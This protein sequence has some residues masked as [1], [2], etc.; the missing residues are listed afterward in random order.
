[1]LK[2]KGVEE[3][4]FNEIKLLNELNFNNKDN[5]KSDKY[6]LSLASRMQYYPTE[7]ILV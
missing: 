7:D 5:E 3:W 6:A 2:Q 4:V 1:M